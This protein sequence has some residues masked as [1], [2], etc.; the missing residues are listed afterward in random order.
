MRRA[1]GIVA[2]M[3]GSCCLVAAGAMLLL[4]DLASVVSRKAGGALVRASW[5]GILF[6]GVIISL[7]AL[8]LGTKRG[9]PGIGL[10]TTAA[11]G[12]VLAAGTLV[13]GTGT[14]VRLGLTF[15]GGLLIWWGAARNV[16]RP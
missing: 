1:G 9:W 2:L 3:A 7:A 15:L 12:F 5:G 8:A 14:T 6:A 4:G 16:A 11:S 10:M 13:V